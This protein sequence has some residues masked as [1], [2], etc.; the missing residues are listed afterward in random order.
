MILVFLSPTKPLETHTL[1]LTRT[2]MLAT[3]PTPRHQPP[4]LTNRSNLDNDPGQQDWWDDVDVFGL[5][6]PEAF[7]CY[8]YSYD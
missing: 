7:R 4:N 8:L 3:V 6:D 2:I 5:I 1:T